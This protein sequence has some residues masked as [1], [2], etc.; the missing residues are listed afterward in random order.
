MQASTL[1]V[2]IQCDVAAVNACA[3]FPTIERIVHRA[4]TWGYHTAVHHQVLAGLS[5]VIKPVSGASG[6]MFKPPQ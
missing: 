3:V 1:V 2:V 4:D 6:V 5:S